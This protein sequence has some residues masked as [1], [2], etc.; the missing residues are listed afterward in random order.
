MDKKQQ[1]VHTA[2]EAQRTA[3]LVAQRRSA[4]KNEMHACIDQQK[5]ALASLQGLHEQIV[6]A[7]ANVV[8]K[9]VLLY[10]RLQ[11]GGFSAATVHGQ[12]HVGAEQQDVLRNAALHIPPSDTSVS[13]MPGNL[14]MGCGPDTAGADVCMFADM[15]ARSIRQVHQND[16]FSDVTCS[17]DTV[18]IDR[19]ERL[20]Q[21]D[22]FDPYHAHQTQI[23]CCPTEAVTFGPALSF[24]E[25]SS[26]SDPEDYEPMPCSLLNQGALPHSQGR[27]A[28]QLYM[29]KLALHVLH[30]WRT[31]RLAALDAN[32][33][34]DEF[35]CM[36]RTA[37][38]LKRWWRITV[39]LAEWREERLHT[40][41][42]IRRRM[43]L[44][45]VLHA[46]QSLVMDQ[47]ELLHKFLVIR[48]AHTRR[49]QL[50]ALAGLWIN[51]TR[52]KSQRAAICAHR[53]RAA[54]KVLRSWRSSVQVQRKLVERVL[55]FVAVTAQRLL[56]RCL[57]WWQQHTRRKRK[58]RVTLEVCAKKQAHK[59]CSAVFMCW[60]LF[61]DR[62]ALL[63]R[64]F[65]R[66]E[67]AWEAAFQVCA[68]YTTLGVSLHCQLLA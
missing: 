4:R 21:R 10:Q 48:C 33:A 24:S 39:H 28:S 56:H 29:R 16:A 60:T 66:A 13:S 5:V 63:Q 50:A 55:E 46:W 52:H 53:Q 34:A 15:E 20:S 51:A 1:A 22:V 37:R 36:A 6:H 61:L 54:R 12:L 14:R 49:L 32:L 67:K 42:A 27:L 7:P 9:A 17:I 57:Q 58:N 18:R 65:A 25:D 62:K 44:S 26:E 23:S 19:L 2:A 68:H 41:A 3:E 8:N 31:L 64:V 30:A 40:S 45:W 35:C 38:G 59:R 11:A 43:V 47:H